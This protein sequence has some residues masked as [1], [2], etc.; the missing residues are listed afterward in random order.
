MGDMNIHI[1]WLTHVRTG[2]KK[3]NRGPVSDKNYP[4]LSRGA[5]GVGIKLPPPPPPSPPGVRCLAKN[6]VRETKFLKKLV[7]RTLNPPPPPPL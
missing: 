3:K 5:R 2:P 6:L 4:T 7:R 1:T